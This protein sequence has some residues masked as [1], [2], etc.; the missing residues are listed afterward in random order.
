L[1]AI[2]F[3]ALPFMARPL[4]PLLDVA[5]TGNADRDGFRSAM[6]RW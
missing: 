3:L 1:I 6:G 2:L 4:D 5:G